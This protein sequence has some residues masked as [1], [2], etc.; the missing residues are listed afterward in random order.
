[1]E[2]HHL[3]AAVAA[4]VLVA[5]PRPGLGPV[6]GLPAQVG[7]AIHNVGGEEEQ[8]V[9][10]GHHRDQGVEG[11][12]RQHHLKNGDAK[13]RRVNPRQPLGLDRDD[14]EEQEL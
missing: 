1:M 8:V 13:E 7:D 6:L 2:V 5:V 14:E 12:P 10:H 9:Q 3:G 4:V 11:V